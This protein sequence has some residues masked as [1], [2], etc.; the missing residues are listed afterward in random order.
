MIFASSLAG[1][2]P[3]LG[4]V[5]DFTTN[6]Y[7]KHTLQIYEKLSYESLNRQFCQTRV[8][9]C[10]FLYGLRRVVTLNFVF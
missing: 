10:P 1:N 3:R 4:D 5:G 9:G 8:S 2:I 6:V 7:T